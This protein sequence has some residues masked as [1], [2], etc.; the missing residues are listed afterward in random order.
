MLNILLRKVVKMKTRWIMANICLL[1]IAFLPALV[2][3]EVETIERATVVGSNVTLSCPIINPPGNVSWQTGSSIALP[4]TTC[5]ADGTCTAIESYVRLFADY[6]A[7]S[8]QTTSILTVGVTQNTLEWPSYKCVSEEEVLKLYQLVFITQEDIHPPKCNLSFVSTLSEIVFTCESDALDG[9]TQSLTIRNVFGRTALKSETHVEKVVTIN[10]FINT[11]DASC[12]LDFAELGETREC[13]FPSPAVIH[14][15]SDGA[16]RKLDCDF[17]EAALS[18]DYKIG[19]RLLD[20]DNEEVD[21]SGRAWTREGGRHLLLLEITE[22]DDGKVV[23]CKVYREKNQYDVISLGFGIITFSKASNDPTPTETLTFVTAETSGSTSAP[24]TSVTSNIFKA[25]AFTFLTLCIITIS[26]IIFFVVRMFS[27]RSSK[28]STISK[29]SEGRTNQSSQMSSIQ[30]PNQNNSSN[31]DFQRDE[32]DIKA[33]SEGISISLPSVAGE[34]NNPLYQVLEKQSPASSNSTLEIGEHS[35]N[36]GYN[37]YSDVDSSGYDLVGPGAHGGKNN[38]DGDKI[39]SI[40][41]YEDIDF[42]GRSSLPLCDV[43]GLYTEVRK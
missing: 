18:D 7:S 29:T 13:T 17:D 24:M 40:C 28:D 25:L 26:L 30:R 9:T 2:L 43:S 41:E 38:G 8:N 20:S 16:D 15:E 34:V 10:E 12:L 19:W 14:Q 39:K 3:A 22:D 35:H 32:S 5:S 27:N 42:K 21:I 4:I 36:D 1:H 6:I 37:L 33:P 11:T 23:E 31:H